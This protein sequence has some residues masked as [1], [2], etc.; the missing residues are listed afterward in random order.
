MS[1]S[2]RNARRKGSSARDSSRGSSL[3]GA[4][5][6]RI[7]GPSMR[8]GIDARELSGRITG[9]GRYLAGM[10]REWTTTD[11]ARI[12]EF[13]LYA[14]ERLA[15]SL[16]SRRFPTRVVP[17]NG[18]TW[19]EQMQLPRV[20]AADHLDAFFAPAYTAPL[21]LD[22]PTVVTIHDVSYVAHPEW[23]QLREGAR[24]RWLT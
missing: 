18:G 12:H 22:V 13:V 21:R 6:T 24:R 10:I 1:R 8:I 17:G 20:A 11:R 9:V 5:S 23:F 2:Q 14:P 19:W 7:N 3:R 16:D 4:R 15:T